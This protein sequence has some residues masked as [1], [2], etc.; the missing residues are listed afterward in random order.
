[1]PLYVIT[2]SDGAAFTSDLLTKVAIPDEP[3]LKALTQGP[4]HVQYLGK[5]VLTDAFID[6]IPG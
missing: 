3:D 4:L 2:R 5:G 6:G 1:M